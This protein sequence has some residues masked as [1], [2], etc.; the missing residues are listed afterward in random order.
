MFYIILYKKSLRSSLKLLIEGFMPIV[1][2]IK[3]NH[4]F[5]I[6]FYTL[7]RSVERLSLSE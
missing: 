7:L 4:Q 1:Q 5:L 2:L 3:L 6:V